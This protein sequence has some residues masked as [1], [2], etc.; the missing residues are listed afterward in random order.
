MKK[1]DINKIKFRW[2]LLDGGKNTLL[3]G[4]EGFKEF[5]EEALN[6]K[7]SALRLID[8][9]NE[10]QLSSSATKAMDKMTDTMMLI[11]DINKQI[12]GYCEESTFDPEAIKRLER[13]L[14][15]LSITFEGQY[16]Q[17]KQAVDK[18]KDKTFIQQAEDES[19]RNQQKTELLLNCIKKINGGN[20]DIV[21]DVLELQLQIVHLDK[22]YNQKLYLLTEKIEKNEQKIPH[23][24]ESK[25]SKLKKLMCHIDKSINQINQIEDE[26]SEVLGEEYL[27]QVFNQIKDE[28]GE[29][30]TYENNEVF[31]NSTH[32]RLINLMLDKRILLQRKVEI[33]PDAIKKIK[34]CLALFK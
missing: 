15:D 17:A 28:G 18:C 24:T 26:A 11:D 20:K 31:V 1:I 5:L 23:W 13:R 21:E 8:K 30:T 27:Q 2:Q 4:G 6:L 29:H 9:A 12:L 32:P 22:E 25:Q 33:V 7:E 3:I 16:Q 34:E 14:N 19:N 10:K